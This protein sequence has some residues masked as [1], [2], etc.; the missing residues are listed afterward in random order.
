MIYH[1]GITRQRAAQTPDL[2]REIEHNRRAQLL[3]E[4]LVPPEVSAV[5]LLELTAIPPQYH[6]EALKSFANMREPAR[7]KVYIEFQSQS[8][9]EL[10][11]IYIH[12]PQPDRIVTQF[13]VATPCMPRVA[14]R[15]RSSEQRK[16]DTW[17]QKTLVVT[18]IYPYSDPRAAPR[19]RTQWNECILV[20]GIEH[21]DLVGK[22]LRLLVDV[23]AEDII[24][25][26]VYN[27]SQQGNV[28]ETLSER[29]AKWH[30]ASDELPEREWT[31][32][33][34][35]R[36]QIVADQMLDMLRM[37][38]NWVNQISAQDLTESDTTKLVNILLNSTI[39]TEGRSIGL[40][41]TR[42]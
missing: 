6:T 38:D 33:P 1:V 25:R 37:E 35:P 21:W 16:T 12:G 14:P 31:S 28:K 3:V 29:T 40:G 19:Y 32:V 24:V 23:R 13:L 17:A 22:A 15:N 42:I 7:K 8:R 30:K 20:Q 9:E 4:Y 2:R 18:F 26:N 27:V 5:T 39:D 11:H 34:H 41:G 10:L 36:H